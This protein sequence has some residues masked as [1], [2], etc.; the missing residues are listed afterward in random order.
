MLPSSADDSSFRQIFCSGCL[1]GKRAE[2]HHYHNTIIEFCQLIFSDTTQDHGIFCIDAPLFLRQLPFVFS[3]APIAFSSIICYNRAVPGS[4]SLRTIISEAVPLLSAEYYGT[5]SRAACTE[6]GGQCP[7]PF[8]LPDS[9][10]P[11]FFRLLP[12]RFS[13]N[14]L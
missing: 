5:L 3:L 9:C 8:Y 14:M 1:T 13:Y 10:S 2:P 11:Y 6:P 12:L 7:A 4:N